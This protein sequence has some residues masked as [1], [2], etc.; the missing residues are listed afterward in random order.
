MTRFSLIVPTLHRTAELDRLFASLQAQD[1]T[2]QVIVIDQNADDRIGPIVSRFK[3]KFELIHISS[4]QRGAARARNTGLEIATGDI[5]AFPDDDAWYPPNLLKQIDERFRNEHALAGICVRG[6]DEHG[7]DAGIRWRKRPA[8]INRLNV[9]RTG[10]EWSMFVRRDA[11]TDIRFN[12][13]LGPGANTPWG[14]GE[15]ADFL[16]HV[17]RK[18]R[19]RYDPSLVVHHPAQTDDPLTKEKALGYARGLGRVLK[20]NRYPLPIAA[21]LCFGPSVRAVAR[22]ARFDFEG[23]IYAQRVALQ[24][25]AGYRAEP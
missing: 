10:I 9:W 25:W 22:V 19:V 15:G 17:L 20:L 12:E 8:Q 21:L 5:V 14:A 23:G 3:S 1:A 11:V 18:G 13:D 7:L 4:A 6:T 16:L 2:F 24:R